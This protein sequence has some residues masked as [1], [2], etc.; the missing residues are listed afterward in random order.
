M[1]YPPSMDQLPTDM[2]A[3]VGAIELAPNLE[4]L[5]RLAFYHAETQPD[6]LNCIVSAYAL[7][8]TDTF[9]PAQYR[10]LSQIS[11]W[12]LGRIE[13]LPEPSPVILDQARSKDAAVQAF[14]KQRI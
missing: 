6:F 5:M 4:S 3:P 13:A 10:Q 12:A 2:A 9:I 8:A 11:E 1:S 14:I 7:C